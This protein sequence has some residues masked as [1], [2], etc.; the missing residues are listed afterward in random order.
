MLA[1]NASLRIKSGAFAISLDVFGT[2]SLLLASYGLVLIAAGAVVF[3]LPMPSHGAAGNLE[4]VMRAAR[5]LAFL[6]RDGPSWHGQSDRLVGGRPLAG[7]LGRPEFIQGRAGSRGYFEVVT[8]L[9][10]GGMAHYYRDYDDADFRGS[11]RE[12]ARFGIGQTFGA[13]SLIQRNFGV[14][15]NHGLKLVYSVVTIILA[16]GITGMTKLR[17]SGMDRHEPA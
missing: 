7:M 6:H 11:M 3:L 15:G 8:P 2:M 17:Q 5:K 14:L 4:G 9:A 10:A 1:R 13:A 12:E 16:S